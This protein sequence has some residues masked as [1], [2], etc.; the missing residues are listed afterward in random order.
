M[1]ELLVDAV[2]GAGVPREMTRDG[3]ALYITQAWG[4]HRVW[5]RPVLEALTEEELR[6]LYTKIKDYYA[7]K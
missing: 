4:E 1:K 5:R 2:C 6:T 3:H 7:G